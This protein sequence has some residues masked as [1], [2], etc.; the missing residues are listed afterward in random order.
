[1]YGLLALEMDAICNGSDIKEVRYKEKMDVYVMC[2]QN[3]ELAG[4]SVHMSPEKDDRSDIAYDD[5]YR[6]T[7]V[8]AKFSTV[9]HL[10]S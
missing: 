3:G 7:K 4:G 8:W 9:Y 5:P 10:F 6:Y 1:M 2:F